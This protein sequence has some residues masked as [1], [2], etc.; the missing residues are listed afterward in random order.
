MKTKRYFL[1]ILV[2][3]LL[4]SCRSQG[5]LDLKEDGKIA[6]GK[7]KLKCDKPQKTYTKTVDAALT[8]SVAKLEEIDGVNLNATLKTEVVKLADY[9]QQGL[10]LDL[11]IFRM[12][13]MTNN[14]SMSSEQAQELITLAIKT[15]NNKMSIKEQ[16]NIINQLQVELSAN[17]K[18]ANELKLNT[19]TILSSLNLI[20]G[21]KILRNKNI[22]ILPCLF[23]LS[24]LDSKQEKSVSSIVDEGLANYQKLDLAN[25]EIEKQK[26]SDT[27]KI[28]ALT[29]DK[30]LPTLS[31]LADKDGTRYKIYSNVWDA[32]SSTLSKID[33]FDITKFQKTY[34][35]LNSL[36]NNY[37]IVINRATDYLMELNS[38]FKPEDNILKRNDLEK[39]L[40][41][42]RL[43]YDLIVTYSKSLVDNITNLTILQAA[44]NE[45]LK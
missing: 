1:V 29:L 39:I 38:F 26:F 34:S 9:S 31:S 23:P 4:I 32:N 11:L 12:C 21:E 44:V 45:S 19:E 36:K 24:N 33:I 27:G 6:K 16:E 28:I 42:E 5:T 41:S 14:K 7:V 43:A 15:W 18:S 35:E 2:I 10:D 3:Q 20:S 37:N 8:G 30:T 22:A 25:N 13:Q 17:L 40:T